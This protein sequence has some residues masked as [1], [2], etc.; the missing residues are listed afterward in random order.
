MRKSRCGIP[1]K[2]L[3]FQQGTI[4]GPT[5]GERVERVVEEINI[6]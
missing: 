1:S 3:T 6:A 5:D 4:F 2:V